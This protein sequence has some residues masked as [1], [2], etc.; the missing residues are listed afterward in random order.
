MLKLGVQHYFTPALSKACH[1]QYQ[2]KEQECQKAT[3]YI[4]LPAN[5]NSKRGPNVLCGDPGKYFTPKKDAGRNPSVK[6]RQFRRVGHNTV[7]ATF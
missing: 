4:H 3:I 5:N 1:P 6:T 2:N 7:F